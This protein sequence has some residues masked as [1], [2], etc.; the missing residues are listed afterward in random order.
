MYDKGYLFF[1]A[2]GISVTAVDVNS[3]KHS[4]EQPEDE[5]KMPKSVLQGKLSALAIQIGYIGKRILFIMRI[6]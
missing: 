6:F 3:K 4:D 2:G 1:F 5:G